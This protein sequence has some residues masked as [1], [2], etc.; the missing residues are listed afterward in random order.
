MHSKDFATLIVQLG[1]CMM[2]SITVPSYISYNTK[3]LGGIPSSSVICQ[4][5]LQWYHYAWRYDV[6][7]KIFFTLLYPGHVDFQSQFWKKLKPKS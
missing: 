7:C 1:M 6:P 5:I 2:S 3:G 4:S